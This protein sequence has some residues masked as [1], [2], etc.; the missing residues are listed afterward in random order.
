MPF[1]LRPFRRALL[2]FLFE[3]SLIFPIGMGLLVPIVQAR[4]EACPVAPNPEWTSNEKRVWETICVGKEV[5]LSQTNLDKFASSSSVIRAEFLEKIV[6]N[7]KYKVRLET[8]GLRVIGA[9]VTG[10]LD[11]SQTSVSFPIDLLRC[12]FEGNVNLQGLRTDRAYR[13]T[14]QRFLPISIYPLLK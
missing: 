3:L 11:L 7:N 9:R 5:N 1:P 12:R 10:L 8:K 13:L 14:V 4:G 2:Y 6:R